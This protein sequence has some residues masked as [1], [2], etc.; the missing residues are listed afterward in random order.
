MEGASRWRSMPSNTSTK[1]KVSGRGVYLSILESSTV[2]C[3]I[4]S[5]L[6]GRVSHCRASH[7]FPTRLS[8]RWR[9]VMHSIE[10]TMANLTVGP[11]SLLSFSKSSRRVVAMAVLPVA[12]VPYRTRFWQ[13]AAVGCL[14]GQQLSLSMNS[15]TVRPTPWRGT[16][17][18]KS[19]Q[20]P[21]LGVS[22]GKRPGQ[23]GQDQLIGELEQG[24]RHGFDQE[25]LVSRAI[26]CIGILCLLEMTI[27][28]H[29]GHDHSGQLQL[30]SK[31]DER[32]VVTSKRVLQW[33]GHALRLC[34]TTE[35]ATT[36]SVPA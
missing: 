22:T 18:Y 13:G 3:D 2:S 31:V 19:R 14:G 8:K 28:G 35:T 33:T 29:V 25:I 11:P 34:S 20:S 32:R 23:R 27:E 9:V 16:Y 21:N 15:F 10:L 1:R 5:H 24:A 4:V 36:T 12:S 17:I 6:G 26:Y 30:N 7:T